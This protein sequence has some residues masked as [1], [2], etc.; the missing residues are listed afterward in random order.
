MSTIEIDSPQT[1]TPQIARSTHQIDTA[2][3]SDADSNLLDTELA[4]LA[5]LIDSRLDEVSPPVTGPDDPTYEA[6]G[7]EM[8]R[9]RDEVLADLGERDAAYIR[10]VIAVQRGLEIG[11]RLALMAGVLPPAWIM[12]TAMLATSKI[13]ENMEIGHNVMH[14]QWDWMR[15]PE[16]HS[17]DLGVGQRVPVQPVEAHPQRDP[18][19][20]DQ[21]LRHGPGHR[22]RAAPGDPRAEV[23]EGIPSAARLRLRAGAD[24]PVGRRQ[25]RL[26]HL[27]PEGR[28]RS[29]EARPDQD[30]RVQGQGPQ[31]GASRTTSSSRRWPVPCS[32]RSSPETSWPTPS[33]TCGPS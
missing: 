30:G 8:D 22:L 27:P 17:T 4:E 26:R 28:L 2:P 25:P 15:D 21:R 32:S 23:V 33:A 12:G 14:G 9:L 18:P 13:L 5:E 31:A 3:E 11:G 1:D 20:V 7:R 29:I 16:I 24:V 6:F 19:H 10:R